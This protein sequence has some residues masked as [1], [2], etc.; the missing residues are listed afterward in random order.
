MRWGSNS[1]SHCSQV[2]V[3]PAS[4]V[5]RPLRFYLLN[6]C[7]VQLGQGSLS[8]EVWRCDVQEGELRVERRA[9]D[10]GQSSEGLM[11]MFWIKDRAVRFIELKCVERD[12]QCVMPR[13][14]DP[15]RAAA[16]SRIILHHNH[17][18]NGPMILPLARVVIGRP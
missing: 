2:G 9:F 14:G 5:Q 13:I 18:T 11:N 17:R 15:G 1:W 6:Q 8:K 12:R 4:T 10:T 16:P 3:E 7:L